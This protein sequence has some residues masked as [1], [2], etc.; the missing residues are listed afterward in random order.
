[1]KTCRKCKLAQPLI[2]FG[3]HARSSDGL[4]PYCKPCNAAQHK[5]WYAKAPEKQ[6]RSNNNWRKP[7]N[8]AYD[9]LVLARAEALKRIPAWADRAAIA[10]IYDKAKALREQGVDCE[11]DHIVPLVSELVSGLHVES[12]LQ[13]VTRSSNATKSNREWPGRP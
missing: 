10:A 13:L 3:R 12:N 8:P 5:E 11:V 2:A 6:L 7:G 9:R 4:Q 1:M